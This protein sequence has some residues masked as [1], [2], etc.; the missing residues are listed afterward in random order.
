MENLDLVQNSLELCKTAKEI[1]E[2]TKVGDVFLKLGQV[3]VIGSLR[4]KVMYRRDIDLFVLSDTID[5]DKAAET[6]KSFIDSGFFQTVGFADYQTFPANDTPAGF[7]FE[8]IVVKDS[9][10]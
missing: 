10:K 7:F 4:L 9:E 1:M 8:L 3:E 5:K 6:A 2:E